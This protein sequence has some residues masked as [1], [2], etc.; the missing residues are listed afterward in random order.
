MEKYEP[1]LGQAFFG[2]PTKEYAAPEFVIAMI[3]HLANEIERVEW[4]LTEKEYDAPITNNGGEYRTDVFEMRAYYWGD[5]E[6]TGA[7]PN[8]KCG[9]VE[10]CWY[11]HLSR[12]T[13]I[14]KEIDENE[15]S[16]IMEKCLASVRAK[17][18]RI[19]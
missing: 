7:L 19:F 15:F 16:E 12:G 1:E 3:K 8:F 10:V 9:D 11:K 14:N 18:T 5:D 4:N 13:T 6:E 2:N 17:D